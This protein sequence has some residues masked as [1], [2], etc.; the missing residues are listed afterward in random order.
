M[1]LLCPPK[2]EMASNVSALDPSHCASLNT[3]A[4]SVAI[5]CLYFL[6]F[7]V[8]LLLN[9]TAAWVSLHLHCTKTFV[10]YLKNLVAADL[11]MTLMIPIIAANKLPGMP[12]GLRVFDCRFASVVFYSCMYTSII[13]MGLISLDRFFKIV[14][15]GGK[16][17]GQSVA[18]SVAASFSVWVTI[19]GGTVLPTIILTNQDPSN[20]TE[21]FC[22]S[23]KSPAGVTLHEGVILSMSIV[24]WV[25]TVLITFCYACITVTV[26]QSFR[27]SGSSNGE[28]KNKTKSRVFLILLVFFVCFVPFQALRWPVTA[29]TLLGNNNCTQAWLLVLH[30]FFRV[31]SA[32][33]ASLD[34]FLYFYLCREFRDK[35]VDLMK[36]RGI[37]SLCKSLIKPR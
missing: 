6:L 20:T 3:V 31:L 25:I 35:L 15:P 8:A 12:V 1:S 23:L 22:L 24:F 17:L 4:T 18:F 7:P 33:N 26:L 28:G 32:S 11:L 2:T 13:L 36:A 5:S 27:K 30:D 21:D 34:P 37:F 9:G 10:V 16:L 29:D 19:F 14:R